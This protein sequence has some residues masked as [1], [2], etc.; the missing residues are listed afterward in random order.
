MCFAWISEQTAIIS[1][2]PISLLVFISEA[3]FVYYAVRIVS[4]NQIQFHPLRAF[5]TKILPANRK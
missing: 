2:Y 3:A 1:L 4:L 5:I